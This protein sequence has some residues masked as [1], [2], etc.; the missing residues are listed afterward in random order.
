MEKWKLIRE[1]GGRYWISNMGNMK[2]IYKTGKERLLKPWI[3]TNGYKMICLSYKGKKAKIAVHRLV[4]L[5]FLD[6]PCNYLELDVNHKDE[7]K[8]NNVVDNLEWC[9]RKE[10]LNHGTHNDRCSKSKINGKLAKKVICVETGV[11]YPSAPEIERQLGICKN[12]ICN[13]CNNKAKTA[14]GYHWQ[15]I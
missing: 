4:A 6:V 12:S 11:I 15:Y 14:G 8:L 2:A 7:N 5:N 3:S 1:F 9:T 10:N 13:C